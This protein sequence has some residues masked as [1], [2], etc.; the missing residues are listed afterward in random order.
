MTASQGIDREGR[1]RVVLAE[2]SPTEAACL[3][4]LLVKNGYDVV[5]AQEG[6]AA[7]RFA[8]E[9]HTDLVISDV[10]MPRMDGYALCRAAKA[11]ATIAEVPVMLLTGL[12]DPASVLRGL[13]SGADD[14][15]LKPYD[16]GLLLSRITS[17]LGSADASSDADEA[18]ELAVIFRGETFALDP[19]ALRRARILLATYDLT[20]GRY[21]GLS[22]VR[23]CL[24]IAEAGID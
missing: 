14:F 7:L 18:S 15:L 20:D 1:C 8:R 2:D 13:V 5:V 11:D 23:N 24:R 21:A 9:A 6:E 4:F 16:E 17:L 19:R 12:S 10:V 3:E 22:E